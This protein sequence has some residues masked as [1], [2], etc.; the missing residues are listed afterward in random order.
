MGVR[1]LYPFLISSLGWAGVA[2]RGETK[3]KLIPDL[4]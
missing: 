2:L 1:D 3:L 4:K